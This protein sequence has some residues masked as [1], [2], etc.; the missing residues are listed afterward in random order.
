L[1]CGSTPQRSKPEIRISRV[2]RHTDLDGALAAAGLT[3]DDE[4]TRRG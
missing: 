4:V 3:S 2:L 1:S